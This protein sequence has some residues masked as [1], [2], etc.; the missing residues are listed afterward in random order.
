METIFDHNIT[1]DEIQALGMIRNTKEEYIKDI[2][3]ETSNG[4]IFSLYILRGDYKRAGEY[5]SKIKD[6]SYRMTRYQSAIG[7]LIDSEEDMKMRKTMFDALHHI[8]D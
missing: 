6:K 1:K 4:D 2:G 7:C 8:L 3:P 5:L